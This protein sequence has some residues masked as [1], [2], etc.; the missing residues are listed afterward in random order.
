MPG[1]DRIWMPGE[2]S[3]EKRRHQREAGIS[4]APQLLET[5]DKLAMELGISKLGD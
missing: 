2:Q 1:V 3:H 5:L 4:L